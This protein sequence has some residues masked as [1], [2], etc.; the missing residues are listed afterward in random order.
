MST[1]TSMAPLHCDT[2]RRDCAAP[3]SLA[4]SVKALRMQKKKPL[5]VDAAGNTSTPSISTGVVLFLYL[6]SSA[7][8]ITTVCLPLTA[9]KPSMGPAASLSTLQAT[10]CGRLQQ[11]HFGS[12]PDRGDVG[13]DTR[14]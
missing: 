12:E 7:P 1:S 14:S 8:G 2:V 5:Q 10:L 9:H 3:G 4:P 11:T 6:N 13:C